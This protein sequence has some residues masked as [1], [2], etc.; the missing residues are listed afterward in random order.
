MALKTI[1][2]SPK[3]TDTILLEINTPHADGCFSS[4]PY[5]VDSVTIYYVE[6]NFLGTNYGEYT[7]ASVPDALIAKLE[8]AKKLACE[9]PSQNNLDNLQKIQGEVESS[10]KSSKF[11]YKESVVVKTIGSPAYPAWL[12]SDTTESFL[13]LVPTDADGNPQYGHFTYEWNPNGTIRAGDFFM[14]WTWTPIPDGEK[15]S[16]SVQFTIEGDG[17]AV[18]TIPSHVTPDGKYETLLERYLPEM[19]KCT[20]ADKDITPQT[21]DSF[22]QAVAQGFTFVEDMANQVID[23]FDANALHE[24][25]LSYLSNTFAIKLRSSDTTLWRR[26]IKEAVPLFK[27]K[28]TL[29]GLAEAFAQAGMTLNAYTQYWQLVSPYTWTESFKVV[30]SPVFELS[31][32]D[33]ILPID[34]NNF[35]LWLRRE[36]EDEYTQIT[37]DYVSFEVGDDSILRMTWIG[38]GLSASAIDLF[39]GDIIKVMYQYKEIPGSP[40]Q[41]LQN[42]ILTLPL[43]DQRDEAAQ[44]YPLKNWNVRLIAESDPLFDVLIPVRHPFQDPLVFGYVRTEFA[45][46]E[47][48]YNAEEY[49]G[50]TRPSYDAC[51][52]DKDFIDPCGSCL[53]SSY[54]VD[55]GVEELSNDRMLEAQDIL[56]EY[57]PFH[58]QLH[59]INFT[60]EVNEFVLSPVEH[61]EMLITID[62]AQ[63]VLSGNSNSI[64]NRII[65]PGLNDNIVVLREE[66]TDQ[67]TVLS[68]KVATAYN[69]QITLISPDFILGDLGV[70]SLNNELEILSPSMNAGT[71]TIDHISGSMAKVTSPVTEPVDKSAFTFNLDNITHNT[72]VA[73]ITQD[74][75]VEMTDASVDFETLAV[76][77]QWDVIHTVD[78]TGGPWKIL[79]PTYSMTAYEIV[80][81]DNG[82]IV[83]DGDSNLPTVDT[84]GVSYTLF[85]D[86]DVEIATSTTGDMT[87]KRRGNVNLNDSYIVDI[88]QLF[89]VGDYLAYDGQEY[90]ISGFD[91]INLL[92]D[93]YSDGD[94]F[95]ISIE[96]RRRLVSNAVGYFGYTGLKLVTPADHE[97]EFQMLNG[98]NPPPENEITDDSHF[99]ENYMFLI[100]G[101]FYKIASIDGTNVTLSGRE[102][103]W[104]TLAAGGTQVG[105]RIVYFP[106]K[107]VNV[108]FTVFDQ[109]GRDGKDPVIREIY[110]DIDHGTAIVALSMPKSSGIQDNVSQE[111]GISFTIEY[112]D[113]ETW[114]GEI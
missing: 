12:S 113:G 95:G 7:K 48:I 54:S 85:D 86:H 112:K 58:A 97:A 37:K 98:S 28:G 109:L 104:M 71:Y 38:D 66:L 70:N 111:E 91:G 13:T 87:V 31:K 81:V 51:H 94:A 41:S 93:D 11:Y 90:L 60:G 82:V 77:T 23:L 76:K 21:T 42:Y 69:D 22:N 49:N 75:L 24:S 26:Q 55:I 46:S 30:N 84:S 89:K 39:Q 44:Q 14:C 110:S 18:Q 4:D 36:G 57:T 88:N 65:D 6:R 25:L 16:S 106:K 105:Y 56:R 20:L 83:L 5:K 47:N 9:D 15:L 1:N 3:I 33:I 2:E 100:G 29:G 101:E 72:T 103:D 80:D 10:T 107:E 92:I 68:G 114:E 40:E 64:F 52:I 79:I 78:Y 17:K 53:G 50:S 74:D 99:K 32:P 45:Y 102:Q 35:G 96:I 34:D 59:S 67:L 73:S 8:A 43:A 19:Y 61:V 62:Y 63:F 27:K 108:G